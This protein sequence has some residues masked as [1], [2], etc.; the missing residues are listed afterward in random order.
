MR[1][2]NPPLQ[3]LSRLEAELRSRSR[4]GVRPGLGR[5]RAALKDLD[6]PERAYEILHV[7]GTNGKG[8]ISLYL[9]SCL[10]EAG[11]RVGTYLSPHLRDLGERF[12]WQGSPA[13]GEELG[14]AFL[15]LEP[16]LPPEATEFELLTLLG[17]VLF[18]RLG[19]EVLVQ[20]TGLGGRLDATNVPEKGAGAAIGLIGFDH[21]EVLGSS[22]AG[23]ARE[24]AAILK[25]GMVAAAA[26]GP[27]EVRKA[28]EEAARAAGAEIRLGGQDFSFRV[29]EIS[30]R[31][32]RFDY[33][34]R[35]WRMENLFLRLPG[36]HQALNA[37]VTLALLE[38]LEE[39]GWK[40]KEEEIR[41]GLGEAFLPGRGEVREVEGRTVVLDTAH[42]PQAARALS[43]WLRRAAPEKA[44]RG[45]LVVAGLLRDKD[46]P[47]FLGP[48]LSLGRSFFLAP[49]ES[50]RARPPEELLAFLPPG[51]EALTFSSPGEAFRAALESSHPGEVILVTG[52]FYLVGPVLCDGVGDGSRWR[53]DF[54][55]GLTRPPDW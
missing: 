36:G 32:T 17:Y 40:V 48:L 46:A 34:G 13:P 43:A 18:R 42:N 50:P 38:A 55:P 37:A 27:R 39:R 31:G 26:P 3:A 10:L 54:R 22:L 53:F 47:G 44:E 7:A 23:I 33:R 21:Q 28:L 8:S 1:A 4:F 49:P 24:K 6:H 16:S 12:L 45:M 2:G 30:L 41:R 29:G 11:Y 52:S 25:P 51:R 9:S 14:A 15:E 20:E 5:M 19:A 35:R